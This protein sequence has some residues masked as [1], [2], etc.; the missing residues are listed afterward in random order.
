[1][2]NPLDK[3]KGIRDS[4][5][6]G[7]NDIKAALDEAGGDID[8]AVTLLRK[9]G[10]LKAAKR[11]ERSTGAGLV[12]AYVHM[13]RVGVLVEVGCETDFVARTDDFKNFVHEVAMQVAAAS[14]LYLKPTDI[15]PDVIKKEKE[16]YAA[17]LKAQNKPPQVVAKAVE[18]KLQK[19]YGEVCL[20]KQ[21]GIKDA[22]TTVEEAMQ[23]LI[24]KLGE[25]IVIKR[26]SR[27][28]L[29]EADAKS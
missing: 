28:G 8:K 4:T 10:Q 13:G 25:N 27:F 12:D 22:D 19:Y 21:P 14:P 24:A 3:I 7:M 23:A 5:G 6:A 18:A 9:K 1:M 20:L 17:E 2:T 26:F 11:A 29:G 15:P 16:V